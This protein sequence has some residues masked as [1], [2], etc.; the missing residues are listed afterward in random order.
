MS[1]LQRARAER[2]MIEAKKWVRSNVFPQDWS[3]TSLSGKAND[4]WN[5]ERSVFDLF[6]NSKW[7]NSQGLLSVNLWST[8]KPICGPFMENRKLSIRDE[9]NI[10]LKCSIFTGFT[11][12]NTSPCVRSKRLRLYR[13]NAHTCFNMC[14]RGAGTHGDVLNV[15]TETCLVDTLGFQRVTR[16]HHDHNDTHNTTQQHDHNTTQ[17]QRQRQRE[18]DRDRERRQGQ[19][20]KRRRKRRTETRQET[21]R[22]DS[23]CSVVG[24]WPFFCWC[25]DF[26]VSSVCARDLSLLNSVKYDSI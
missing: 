11:D 17:R 25:S 3:S 14:A 4:W 19:R 18:T 1:I 6:S 22:E 12:E 13:H 10:R 24:A 16:T 9:P 15:H 7:V 8:W 23:F 26:L 2:S 20:E 21:E 5:G